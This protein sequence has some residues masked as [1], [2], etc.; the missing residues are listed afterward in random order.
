MFLARG[1][2]RV[3][4]PLRITGGQEMLFAGGV[5]GALE[6]DVLAVARAA[7]ADI[8][9]LVGFFEDQGI[10]GLR[11]SSD[12]PEELELAFG[13]LVLNGVEEGAVIRGPDD[14]A[15]PLG[16]VGEDFASFQILKVKGV[17]PESGD[18]G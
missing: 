3:Q 11:P 10:F 4:S 2:I 15:D 14:R 7:G 12:V 1:S 6:N 8:E 9:A 13:F 16:R 17:L 5:A 18:I